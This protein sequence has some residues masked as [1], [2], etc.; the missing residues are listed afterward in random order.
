MAHLSLIY[1]IPIGYIGVRDPSPIFAPSYRRCTYVKWSGR[2]V[3]VPM[4]FAAHA[5]KGVVKNTGI[6][7]A[8]DF[9][10]DDNLSL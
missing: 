9:F 7:V 5:S 6:A 1:T 4:W 2:V 8:G 3:G 10:H